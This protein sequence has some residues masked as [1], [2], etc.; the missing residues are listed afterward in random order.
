MTWTDTF[1]QNKAYLTPDLYNL[2]TLQ[3]Q[4]Q[5]LARKQFIAKIINENP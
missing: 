1:M 5:S 2:K 3:L 4:T